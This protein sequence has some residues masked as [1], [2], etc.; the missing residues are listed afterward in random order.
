MN[1]IILR[2][3]LFGLQTNRSYSERFLH[4]ILEAITR[5]G[6]DYLHFNP[7]TPLLYKAG[8]KYQRESTRLR[9]VNDSPSV[10]DWKDIPTTLADKKGDCEDL[11]TWRAAELR[12]RFNIFAHAFLIWTVYRGQTV[13]HVTA[14]YRKADGSMVIED[15]SKVLGMGGIA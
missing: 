3:K 11:G 14:R 13:F 15:P 6:V 8:V 10:E 9:G 12:K 7:D 2:A 4:H 1:R 5:A